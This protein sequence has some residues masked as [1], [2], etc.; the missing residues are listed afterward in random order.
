MRLLYLIPYFMRQ[1]LAR[2]TLGSSEDQIF[3]NKT[4]MIRLLKKCMPSIGIDKKRDI[5]A[6]LEDL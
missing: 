3:Q 5:V 1:F 6:T 2:Q 4:S